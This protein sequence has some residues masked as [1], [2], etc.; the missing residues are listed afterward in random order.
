MTV[1][2]VDAVGSTPLAEKLGE[3]EMYSF[4]RECLDRMTKAVHAYEG[5]VA[6]FTGDGLMALFGAPI[7]HEDSARR[8][9]AAALR[10][11]RSL[12]AYA[13]AVE[14]RHGVVPRFRVGLNTGPVVAGTVSD[15]LHMDFTAIGDT[16][17]LAARLEQAAEPGGVLISENTYRV[18]S[19]FFA[20]EAVGPVTVKGKTEPVSVW[21]VLSEG[22]MRTRFEI[23][24]QRGL[25]PLVGR[26]RE[27][28]VVEGY[29]DLARRGSGQAVA[30]SGDPGIGKSRLI[31]ELRQRV[32]DTGVAWLEG[33]CVSFGTSTA[34]LPLIE[35]VKATFGIDETDDEA[36]I[37]ERVD[38]AVS[39]WDESAG[40]A[41]P[42][43][44]YLL[45]VDP[46]DAAVALMDPQERRVGVFDALRT[47][48]LQES[49]RQPLVIVIEDLHWADAMSREAIGALIDIVPSEPVLFIVSHRG[50]S[51]PLAERPEISRL[52]LTHLG[53]EESA[54]LSRNVLD[55]SS[56]PAQLERL[57]TSRAEGNPFYVEE[58]ARALVEMGVVARVDGSYRFER[59]L[60]QVEIPDTIQEVI[61]SRIDRLEHEAKGAMQLASVIGRE[62]T[63]RVLARISQL[64]SKLAVVL[65]DLKALDFIYETASFPELAYMF[66][67]ALTH[68]VAYA[69]LVAERRRA[70]HRL[71]ADA[72][73]V[74]HADRLP[75]H[76][77]VLAHHYSE[78]QDWV[79][80]LDYLEKAG[81][82]ARA[83]Y[84][85]QDA[86][87]FYARA[88]EVCEILGEQALAVAAS[89]AAKRGF[90]GFTIGD[91]PTAVSDFDRM[92]N[93]ARRLGNRSLEG[94]AL[95]Y[96]GIHQAFVGDWDTS[97][98]TLEEAWGIVE[99]GFEEIR[100]L[101]ALGFFYLYTCS[102]R[103]PE[104]EAR[105][106]TAEEA[107]ALPDPFTQGSWNWALG[108]VEHWRGRS[109]EALRILRKAPDAGPAFV[110]NRQ[111][112]GWIESMA[113]GTKGE[114]EA[115]L[116][117]LQDLQETSE[118][119]GD[120]LMPPRVLNTRGW[121]Y[122]ELED[123]ERAME[124]N[125]SSVEII[126]R[127]PGFP[128]PDVQ[129]HG[130]VN[131]GDNLRALGRWDEAEEQYRLAEAVVRS[132]VPTER[133][134]AWRV[135]Q[136][137]FHSYGELCLARGDLTGALAYADECLELALYNSSQKNV[138]K[139]RRLRGEVFMAEGRLAEAEGEL[140]A[141][142]EIAIDVGNPPQLWKTHAAVGELRRAQGRPA[143]ARRAYGEAL[144]V[145][146]RVASSLSDARLRETFLRSN[147]VECIRRAA[148]PRT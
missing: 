121:I 143:D 91:L 100:P 6:T 141:A 57:I 89:L 71:V 31:L 90:L 66:K 60:D 142:L 130:R 112:S 123:H 20:V 95:G 56:L 3:E 70:L 83:A 35:L 12:S 67:H 110:V 136:H 84:A 138:I 73:E 17:N 145:I 85:N 126:D 146:E 133:W 50:P 114:Y 18:V 99:E 139:G 65:G 79:K 16:V 98:T 97:E 72:I 36:R 148:E 87:G 4:M 129:P 45:S 32:A 124:C 63:A 23:A 127:I 69:T 132:P 21:R 106:I 94:I 104:A 86:L 109:D 75:E 118:R 8:A 117:V 74:L 131:L 68:D 7:A 81:D 27:L 26:D 134:M 54:V 46:G 96:R 22:P 122:A 30:V 102:N 55:V 115:A 44:K 1:L 13:S 80:A 39:W 108:S 61:L 51:L 42:Y 107:A 76:F 2:F 33:H 34:Y 119:L 29:F 19:D 135:A 5:H 125:R 64:R 103:L 9:V 101:I 25:S 77:E 62:F 53:V 41:A 40:K 38:E 43:L 111:F 128:L 14:A 88:L 47:L 116:E 37:V 48:L 10:M 140:S 11:Q 15:D 147:H 92:V 78:G 120:I 105:L 93:T 59:P 58:L 28:A 137:L 144:S 82:K 113:L 24:A 52:V 49:A